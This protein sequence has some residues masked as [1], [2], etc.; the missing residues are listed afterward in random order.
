VRV[1]R[2][3]GALL[4]AACLLV[5]AGCATSATAAPRCRP[6][7]RLAI[8]AQSTPGA[9][10]LPCVDELPPGWRFESF[11]VDDDGT[12]FSLRSDRADRPVEVSL[13]SRCDV[14]GATPVA[15]RDEGVRTYQRAASVSPRYAGR[16]YDVFPRG[17]VTY[18]FDFERGPHIALVDDLLRMVQLYPLRQL[19]QELED[20]LGITLE[21]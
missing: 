9:A 17:C 10:Y 7:Q 14:G 13:S 18:A 8:V 12:R 3:A 16:F 4:L 6:G 2:P 19:R 1:A 21:P 15:P 20:E 5:A 11:D